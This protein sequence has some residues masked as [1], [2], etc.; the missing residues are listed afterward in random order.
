MDG[1]LASSLE[2]ELRKVDSATN[3]LR[4]MPGILCSF[5]LCQV[6]SIDEST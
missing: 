3:S 6:L 5:R 4:L 1:R 2:F